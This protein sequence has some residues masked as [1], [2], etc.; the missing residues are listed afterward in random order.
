VVRSK[1]HLK[2]NSRYKPLD[3]PNAVC[4]VSYALYQVRGPE[5]LKTDSTP[6][7]RITSV[8]V[9]RDPEKGMQVSFELA[10][11]GK[12][13]LSVGQNEIL[14]GFARGGQS[15]RD[16]PRLPE[17]FP[18]GTPSRIRVSSRKPTVLTI[19]TFSNTC[20]RTGGSWSDLPAGQYLLC[21]G[22]ASADPEGPRFD[23]HWEGITIS[24]D[25]KLVIK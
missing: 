25:Y 1:E 19:T 22:I 21:V 8:T 18:P 14:V 4:T 16:F 13:P 7:V 3:D 23:Y 17:S 20:P 24:D 2:L 10:A 15:P 5:H 9:P 6:R 11:D 12:T